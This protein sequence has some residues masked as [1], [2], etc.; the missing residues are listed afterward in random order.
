MW[1]PTPM[2]D[3]FDGAIDDDDDDKTP[4]REMVHYSRDAL[5]DD[6]P[7]PVSE[8][9]ME[10]AVE[11]AGGSSNAALLAHLE[12]MVS[13]LE[14]ES[15]LPEWEMR[16]KVQQLRAVLEAQPAVIAEQLA[17]IQQYADCDS[18]ADD[19]DDH[20]AGAL[21]AALEAHMESMEQSMR[22][23]DSLLNSDPESAKLLANAAHMWIPSLTHGIVED[24]TAPQN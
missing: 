8:D 19:E 5:F 1:A 7:M 13:S 14:A 6:S 3:H 22:N 16:G 10:V 17:C 21:G 18:P 23:I 9:S 20:A 24:Q 12:Q 2:D 15:G 4:E 11:R